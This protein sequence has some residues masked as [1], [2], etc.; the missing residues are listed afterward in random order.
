MSNKD[1]PRAIK[2]PLDRPIR[3]I[4]EI[5]G[6]RSVEMERFIKFLF[7]GTVGFVVDFGT[8][9]LL[10]STMLPAVD[11]SGSDLPWNVTLAISL[12]FIAGVTSN[13]TWN[14]YW[15]YP[16]SRA[17]NVKTQLAQFFFINLV[18]WLGRTV[19]VTLAYPVFGTWFYPVFGDLFFYEGL[20]LEDASARIGTNITLVIGVFAVLFWNFFANRYWT[21]SDV[22]SRKRFDAEDHH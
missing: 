11:S 15:T 21:Y 4:A 18:G 20:A 1:S 3:S 6:E 2:T 14:R 7:V 10:Q 13:F 16:D 5:F 9:N 19:W 17:R 22:D 12:S 8:L